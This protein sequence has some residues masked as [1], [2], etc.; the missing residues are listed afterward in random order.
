MF[1]G[2]I[3]YTITAAA[4]LELQPNG[5]DGIPVY[6][7]GTG[8]GDDRSE[9]TRLTGESDTAMHPLNLAIFMMLFIVCALEVIYLKIVAALA[10][11]S[12]LYSST[13][14]GRT[15]GMPP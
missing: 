3:K 6:T 4:A 12:R 13:Q 8:P 7:S 10:E 14:T 9:S 11:T 15:I 1:L 5:G 2:F